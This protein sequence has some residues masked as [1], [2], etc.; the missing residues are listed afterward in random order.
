MM[1]TFDVLLTIARKIKETRI[2]I[3]DPIGTAKLISTIL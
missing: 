2:G 3:N 1:E